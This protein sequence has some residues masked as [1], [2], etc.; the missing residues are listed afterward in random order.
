L[1]AIG[2]ENVGDIR[3]SSLSDQDAQM[4]V[5]LDKITERLSHLHMGNDPK[6]VSEDDRFTTIPGVLPPQYFSYP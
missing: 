5:V 2:F 1:I 3:L 6:C 4:D